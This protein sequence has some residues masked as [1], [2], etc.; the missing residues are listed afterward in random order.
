M[1]VF[2]ND[3]GFDLYIDSHKLVI[4]LG[5]ILSLSTWLRLWFWHHPGS[6]SGDVRLGP[7]TG[8]EKLRV[9]QKMVQA[10]TDMWKGRIPKI[11]LQGWDVFLNVGFNMMLNA[12]FN[13][14]ANVGLNTVYPYVKK[15]PV[16]GEG[17]TYFVDLNPGCLTSKAW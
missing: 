3:T 6:F 8:H 17:L 16:S 10:R 4:I 11:S 5:T 9:G 7:N 14:V 2:F 1:C 13:M 15:S 12:H